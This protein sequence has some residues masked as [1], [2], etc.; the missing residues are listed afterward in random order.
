MRAGIVAFGLAGLLG[1][2]GCSKRAALPDRAPDAASL[3]RCGATIDH[4]RICG[5][6]EDV[7]GVCDGD[8]SVH[9]ALPELAESSCFVPVR[10]VDGALPRADD[11]PDGCGY[12]SSSG[13]VDAQ[14]QAEA[15]RYER[16]AGGHEPSLPM[17]FDCDLSDSVR[18]VAATHD[19]KA[20]RA[21]RSRLD[22]RHAYAA[23]ATF[24]YGTADMQQSPLADWQPGDD[25]R[26][27]DKR[28]MDRLSVNVQRAGLAAASFHGGV[29]PIVIVSG[30]AV[31]S[32]PMIEAF[33]LLHLLRCR[34]DVPEDAVLLDPCADHTHTNLRNT[35]GLIR[36]IGGR[37]GYVVTDDVLQGGYLQE[38]TIFWL[39]GGSVDQ[40][41][42]RDWGYLLGAWRQA[43][44]GYDAGFW[45]TP[46]R[47]WG[48][49]RDGL[50]GVSCV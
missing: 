44:V 39:V 23:I 49:P 17:A 18:R 28:E 10:H 3:G 14:L 47:F 5:E 31:R 2:A 25:C 12:P 7:V 26:A 6:W 19:A 11:I 42:L 29:A 30:A 9:D 41:A 22:R 13:D 4:A 8:A 40:R 37:Q 43:S 32:A 15:A 27:L 21:L 16:I 48:E 36:R 33:M 50:G 1:G 46:Y 34:F 20:L 24:G 38:W 35:G 45:F